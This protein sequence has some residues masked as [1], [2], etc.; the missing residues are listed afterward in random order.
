RLLEFTTRQM[1]IT[2]VY[3][4][5][6]WKL[7]WISNTL[8]NVT[9]YFGA[10]LVVWRSLHGQSVMPLTLIL[11]FIYSLGVWK[12]WLRYRAISLLLNRHKDELRKLA[13]AYVTLPPFMSL[14][15]LY[16]MIVLR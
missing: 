7:A 8:F 10:V 13:W 12:G 5:L 6:I 14:L 16:N 4:P 11:A 15:W 9:F 2:R 3:S 1:I